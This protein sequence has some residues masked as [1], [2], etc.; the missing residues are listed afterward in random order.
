LP[1]EAKEYLAGY[2]L[3]DCESKE[4]A[5]EVAALIRDAKV[6]G[7]GI[8]VRPAGRVHRDP[9][10]RSRRPSRGSASWGS[11]GADASQRSRSSMRA[12][13]LTSPARPRTPSRVRIGVQ[14]VR[15]HPKISDDGPYDLERSV[16]SPGSASV[17]SS[18]K[19]LKIGTA[20]ED[21][22]ARATSPR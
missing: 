7:L 6:D 5:L 17:S 11:A 8:E 10:I 13:V 9:S 3:I 19:A 20:A 4:R 16:T 21:P 14:V 1:K 2:Y 22:T 12:F 15:I 18:M